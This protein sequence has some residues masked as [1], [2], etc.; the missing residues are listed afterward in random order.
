MKRPLVTAALGA[1]V[2]VAAC[3]GGGEGPGDPLVS[4]SLTGQFKGQA[5]VPAFGFATIYQGS[6]LIGLGDGPLNCSSPERSEPP[7]GTNALF[8]M[9]ALD[10]GSYGQVFVQIL[11]NKGNFEGIGSNTGNVMITA[12][13]ATSV[14]GSIGYSYTDAAGLTYGVTGSFEV[15]RCPM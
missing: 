3:G 13:S 8:T 2:A 12:A 9:S 15:A 14:A 7:S 6:N 11:Q 5:F 10:V 4:G 1:L